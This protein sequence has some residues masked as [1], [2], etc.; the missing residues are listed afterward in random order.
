MASLNLLRY[1]V[2]KDCESDNQ[3]STKLFENDWLAKGWELD[4]CECCY[5]W[6]TSMVLAFFFAMISN[7]EVMFL[8]ST[9]GDM[10]CV[11]WLI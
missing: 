7:P 2:I 8:L 3:V 1:L 5:P 11:I 4:S 6:L 10:W 9:L